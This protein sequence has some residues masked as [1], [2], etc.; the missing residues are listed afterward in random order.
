MQRFPRKQQ[1]TYRAYQW[2]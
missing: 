2:A 1:E